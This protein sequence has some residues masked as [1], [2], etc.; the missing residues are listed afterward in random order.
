M[1]AARKAYKMAGITDPAKEIQVA[2]IADEY[3][4]QE[5]LWMEGLG[6]CGRGQ[7]GKMI[8]SGATQIG[9][10]LPVNTLGGMLAGT[11]GIVAGMTKV[12]AAVQ[13]L[14]GEAGA[15]QVDGATVAVT[16]GT[17]GFCGSHH[18]VMT[19]SSK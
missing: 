1:T 9:G 4:H 7:A 11:P 10:A 16:Q 2:E 17:T 5:L 13:Q 8:D 14:R 19:L 6:L 15:A 18:C 3:A 12:A